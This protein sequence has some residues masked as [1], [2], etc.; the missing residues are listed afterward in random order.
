ML[1]S[2]S[3]QRLR[4][5]LLERRLALE[6]TARMEMERHLEAHL[7]ASPLGSRFRS[8]AG[9][10]P[11]RTEVDIESIMTTMSTKGL[12]T[13]L[14]CIEGDG[15]MVFRRWQPG[16]PLKLGKYRI[17]APYGGEEIVPE[18]I[19]MPLLACDLRGYRLGAGGGYYD[20]TL[21]RPLYRDSYRLGVGFSFQLLP[22]LPSEA[23][24]VRLHAF[25]S[26]TGIQEFEKSP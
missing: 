10:F 4:E 21:S 13:S 5:T 19:L 18:L 2:S 8:V 12:L 1:P 26:E 17:P 9:Y 15:R 24:D 25:L 20:R 23:H 6:P 3:K 11:T 16:D 22:L 14:P 7:E